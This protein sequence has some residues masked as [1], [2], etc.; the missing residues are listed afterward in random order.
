MNAAA[1]AMMSELPDVVVAYGVSDEFR[2]VF[3]RC[4]WWAHGAATSNRDESVGFR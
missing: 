2:Y 1:V 3:D 4:V